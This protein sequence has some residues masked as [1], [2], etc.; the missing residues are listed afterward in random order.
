MIKSHVDRSVASAWAKRIAAPT[1]ALAEL[2]DN[3]TFGQAATLPVAG[4]TA[5]Y[6]LRKGGL[7]LG[8]PALITGATGGVGDF[9]LQLARL[10]GARVVAH[11]RRADQE[12]Q[13]RES[14]ADAVVVGEDLHDEMPFGP[15]HLIVDS[16]GG[17]TLAAALGQIGE[18]GTVVSLGATGGAEVT[19]D[20]SRFYP[21]GLASLYG[22]ILFD[23]LKA[24]PAGKGLALLAGLISSGD[25]STRIS[26]EMNW[27]EVAV[28]A[29]QLTD[30]A[31]PG[32][33][34]LH[35]G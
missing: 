31:Y 26:V 25:L 18:G 19:F 13:A 1:N 6:A 22:F 35:L 24:E 34:V 7:L 12:A 16:V 33:A 3:V 5:L 11:V 8:R 9:A 30:R 20:V 10:S 21:I 14:G 27:S 4:L 28:A 23:E 32:K 2:P 17:R 29:R 15:Y